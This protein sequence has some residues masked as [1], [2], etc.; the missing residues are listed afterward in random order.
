MRAD[1]HYVDHL[2]SHHSAAAIRLIPTRHIDPPAGSL[3]VNLTNTHTVSVNS[4]GLQ[5]GSYTGTIIVHAAGATT[6]SAVA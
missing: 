3:R 6:E 1:S 4:E 5:E 2:E